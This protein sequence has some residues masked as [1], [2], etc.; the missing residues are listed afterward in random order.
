MPATLAHILHCPGSVVGG[1]KLPLLG[2]LPNFPGGQQA[3]ALPT[4]TQATRSLHPVDN[5]ELNFLDLINTI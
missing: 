3:Q 1:D 5:T 4:H 2:S